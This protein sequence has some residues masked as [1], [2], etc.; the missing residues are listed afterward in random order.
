MA[1]GR[2]S[3]TLGA[4]TVSIALLVFSAANTHARTTPRSPE[5]RALYQKLERV[6]GR[7]A[8]FGHQNATWEGSFGWQGSQPP[9]TYLSDV[10]FVS[11]D[12]PA[13]YGWDLLDISDDL[14]RHIVA[15]HERGGVNTI[16]WHMPNPV[17]GGPY[18]DTTPALAT[19]LPGGEDHS[20][21][22]ALL[23]RAADFMDSL[24]DSQGRRI[25]IIFRPFHEHNGYW[26][27]WGLQHGTAADF[28]AV[29]RFTVDYL[30]EVRGLDSLII[31]YSPDATP[32][33]QP[34]LPFVGYPGDDVV[35]IVGLDMYGDVG[36]DTLGLINAPVVRAKMAEI[37]SF[38]R[39]RGKLA[40]LTETGF[41]GIPDPQ[42]WTKLLLQTLDPSE[43]SYVMVW[44]NAHEN[45]SHYY[46]PKPGHA[47]V[48]DFL[49][50]KASGRYWFNRD[51]AGATP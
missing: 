24:R 32:V 27:W 12:Y 1:H 34:F 18:T 49:L 41:E 40:A 11:G 6:R 10:L 4:V 9:G 3:R 43:L 8:L 36:R 2:F 17:T 20:A 48:P 47:S 50:M 29:F 46:A 28:A 19:I 22:V 21:F 37:T 15:A 13:L 14:R 31:A 25:P 23:D 44:R 16:S 38:A 35:D 30:V 42:W 39:A 26:F 5:A 33:W 7:A 51:F 45:A